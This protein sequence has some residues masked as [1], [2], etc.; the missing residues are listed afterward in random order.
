MTEDE[1]EQA[2]TAAQAAKDAAVADRDARIADVTLLEDCLVQYSEQITQAEATIAEAQ[3]KLDAAQSKFDEVTAEIPTAQADIAAKEAE[4]AALEAE[5]ARLQQ[6]LEDMA[7][8]GEVGVSMGRWVVRDDAHRRSD[9]QA[10]KNVGFSWFRHGINWSGSEKPRGTIQTGTARMVGEACKVVGMKWLVCLAYTPLFYSVNPS[11]DKAPPK[12]EF[13]DE[14]ERWVEAQIRAVLATGLAVTN[15]AFEIWNEENHV[16]F[17]DRPD[18][19]VYVQLLK[20]ARRAAN[21]VNPAVQIIFGGMAPAPDR[22]GSA[23]VKPSYRSSTFVRK[24]YENGMTGDDFNAMNF[25]PY[26]GQQPLSATAGKRWDMNTTVYNEV[27]AEMA[28][29]GDGSKKMW[30]TEFGYGTKETHGSPAVSEADQGRLL[31]DQIKFLRSRPTAGVSFVFNW[32][33][34]GQPSDGNFNSYGIN[35]WDGP[36]KPAVATIKSYLAS[37]PSR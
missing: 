26:N 14:W 27:V 37:A 5:I 30:S 31:V 21:K 24:C 36:P 7:R 6:E 2:I 12:P 23:T 32:R 3:A 4:I 25:H 15:V 33:E 34:M 22:A 10:I 28:K 11:T 13:Y 9:L 35:R 19:K 17:W 8:L 29:H 16:G 1:I 20:R 18:P